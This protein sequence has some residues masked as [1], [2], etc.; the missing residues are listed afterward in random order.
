MS[1]E[2][3]RYESFFGQ[4]TEEEQLRIKEIASSLGIKD[5][6]AIWIIIYVM[7]YF[8]RFYQ[9]LPQRLKESAD[10]SVESVK[11][12]CVAAA[13]EEIERTK[14]DLSQAVLT[15]ADELAKR[16]G[17][18]SV[19]QPIA[20]LCCGIYTLCLLCFV[21]GAAVAGKGWG[22]NPF[23][24]LLAAPAG[25]ILPIAVLPVAIYSGWQAWLG[26]RYTGNRRNIAI[27]FGSSALCALALLCFLR[28]L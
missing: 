23:D 10:A 13:D 15:H 27:L 8:G 19:V 1:N 26:Y 24:S 9:N 25:W 4:G 21:A 18:Y 14:S 12:R 28:V 17:M 2:V 3:E 7:N 16:R 20:W 11:A 22:Q 5:N 6:D